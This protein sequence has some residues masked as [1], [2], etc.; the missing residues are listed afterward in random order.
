MLSLIPELLRSLLPE[1]LVHRF[2]P[3]VNL[4]GVT[5]LIL[6]PFSFSVGIVF[7]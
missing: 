3:S 5:F 7:N 2:P 1:L 6:F 4:E